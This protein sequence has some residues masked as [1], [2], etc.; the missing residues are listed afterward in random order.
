MN[1]MNEAEIL[2]L[3]R[4][5][6]LNN[7]SVSNGYI[8]IEDPTCFTAGLKQ[9]L[10]YAWY[11]I[12]AMTALLLIGWAFSMIRGGSKTGTIANN[13]AYLLILFGGLSMAGPIVN[14]L[15]GADLWNM[16]CD[17]IRVPVDQVRDILDKRKE[18]LRTRNEDDL[19][20]DFDIYDSAIGN[21]SDYPWLE[22]L[23]T[24]RDGITVIPG[25]ATTPRPVQ[26]SPVQGLGAHSS[27]I[28]NLMSAHR[29][30]IRQ[31]DPTGEGHVGALRKG[32]RVHKGRDLTADPGVAVPAFFNGTVKGEGV[33]SKG[34]LRF[35]DIWWDNGTRSRIGYVKTHLN[36]GDRVNVGEI[37]GT[38]QNLS[39]NPDYKGVQNHIHFELWPGEIGKGQPMD[40]ASM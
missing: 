12:I 20:E 37:I 17:T 3:L 10:E 27:T 31:G 24:G 40:I 32:G 26:P 29:I 11:V 8:F 19:W 15:Y 30:A 6:G 16:G 21:A 4:N 23:P 14:F 34:G 2:R 36:Y 18:T 25:T 22:D 9:M 33:F 28:S 1:A 35:V 13:I 38:V 39:V 5:S 7:L